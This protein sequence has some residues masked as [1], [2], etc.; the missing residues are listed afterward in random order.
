MYVIVRTDPRGGFVSKPG[1]LSSYTQRLQCARVWSTQEEAERER[2]PEGE[3]I[4]SVDEIMHR[5]SNI[6]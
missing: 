6:D 2:C 5:P 4:R 1:S 3:V